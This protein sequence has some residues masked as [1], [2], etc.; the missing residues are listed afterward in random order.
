MFKSNEFTQYFQLMIDQYAVPSYKEINPAFYSIVS[1]PFLFGVMYGDIGHGSVLLA[2][3]LILIMFGRNL[4]EKVESLKDIYEFRY[5]L[6]LMALFSVYC[7]IMYN[8]FMSIP[9]NLFPSCYSA[10]TGHRIDPD[11]VYPIGVDPIWYG[12][13]QELIFLNSLKMKIS[14]I[15]AIVH[16][17]LGIV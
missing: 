10:R 13:K 16:M 9:L 3:A 17:T 11:C 6:L 12:T 5:M 4:V 8:D 2:V 14:V 7:G 1:Y 15:L